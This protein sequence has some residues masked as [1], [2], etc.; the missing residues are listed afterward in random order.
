MKKALSHV[1]VSSDFSSSWKPWT[2]MKAMLFFW[3]R[4]GR[5]QKYGYLQMRQQSEKISCNSMVSHTLLSSP[6]TISSTSTLVPEEPL[7]LLAVWA[8][9]LSKHRKANDALRLCSFVTGPEQGAGLPCS[10]RQSDRRFVVFFKI[11]K[12]GWGCS[13]FT[14]QLNVSD[15]LRCSF[16]RWQKMRTALTA[17]PAFHELQNLCMHWFLDS[18]KE[19][20]QRPAVFSDMHL[21]QCHVSADVR[22]EL[23]EFRLYLSFHDVLIRERRLQLWAMVATK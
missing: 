22:R 3:M 9:A 19:E 10:A 5:V 15:C 2:T 17:N 18:L 16:F 14:F 8:C 21:L 6:E 7:R 4:T 11:T 1:F 13:F 23:R 12:A 20:Q